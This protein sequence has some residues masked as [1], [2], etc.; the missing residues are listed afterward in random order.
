VPHDQ[1]LGVALS[2]RSLL[3]FPAI[4]ND[5]LDSTLAISFCFLTENMVALS[6]GGKLQ[7]ALT[8]NLISA[9]F[10]RVEILGCTDEQI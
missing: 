1:Q 8:Q 6:K 7:P 2:I 5:E 9:D 3:A 10:R 4:I